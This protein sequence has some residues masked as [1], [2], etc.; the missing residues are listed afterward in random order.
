MN[1][2]RQLLLT[3]VKRRMYKMT[4]KQIYEDKDKS[5]V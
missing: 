5:K 3:D 4:L 1:V 2:Y